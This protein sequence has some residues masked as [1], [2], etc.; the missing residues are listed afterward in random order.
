MRR[1]IVFILITSTLSLFSCRSEQSEGVTSD[2]TITL[3]T[4][5]AG[6]PFVSNKLYT[7]P[8][9]GVIQFEKLS[10]F[11]SDI[12]LLTEDGKNEIALDEIEYLPIEIIQSDTVSAK[13]GWVRAYSSIPVGDY[14][15]V[16]FGLGVNP[17]ENGQQPSDFATSHPL[18]DI[19][20]YAPEYSSYIFESIVGQYHNDGNTTDFT[21]EILKDGLYQEVVLEKAVTITDNENEIIFN[22]DL[23][24]VFERG[25]SIFDVSNNNTLAPNS[26][27]M[28]WLSQ[29]LKN[30]FSF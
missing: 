26:K 7:Y 25:D 27:E 8:S 2:V 17:I 12:V 20:R 19:N 28:E 1:L 11:L 5:F 21:F 15:G 23:E 9:S 4:N 18:S 22:L 16:K 14:T 3:K 13:E 10:L 24:K 30:A 6:Q 29:N